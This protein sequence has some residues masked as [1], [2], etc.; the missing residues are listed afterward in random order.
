M[1]FEEA[2][3]YV[4]EG[5]KIRRKSFKEGVYVRVSKDNYLCLGGGE[6]PEC[7]W[8]IKN[9]ELTA[10]DWEI[11]HEP[12]LEVLDETERKYLE[13]VIRPFKDK[14]LW[15]RKQKCGSRPSCCFLVIGLKNAITNIWL[16]PFKAN[17]MY[18]N[19]EFN[20]HYTIEEL[21]L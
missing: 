7:Y 14:V 18:L 9:S 17:S 4:K 1:K 16:P 3:A 21:D 19:M 13:N 20:K 2:I 6:I 8:V 5:K 15:I 12:I 10:T 11:Y